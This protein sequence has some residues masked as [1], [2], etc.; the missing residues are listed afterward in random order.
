MG[1]D[2]KG[3][4]QEGRE[5]R[6]LPLGP[7]RL[8]E[9]LYGRRRPKHAR[10]RARDAGCEFH[11]AIPGEPSVLDTRVHVCAGRFEAAC[12]PVDVA[13]GVQRDRQSSLIV[14][15]R[16]PRDH[17]VDQVGEG[18]GGSLGSHQERCVRLDERGVDR[19]ALVGVFVGDRASLREWLDR[20]ADPIEIEPCPAEADQI[21]GAVDGVRTPQGCGT[22]EEVLGGAEVGSSGC[23]RRGGG[24]V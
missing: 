1:P 10:H 6:R 11:R 18:L 9:D 23:V 8:F 2:G 15:R 21:P 22:T 3:H 12:L 5:C 16:E 20:V 13:A 4:R 24:Q 17:G 7:T 14:H 19:Q